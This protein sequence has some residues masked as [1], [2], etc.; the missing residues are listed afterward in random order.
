MI[1]ALPNHRTCSVIFFVVTS[2]KLV[3]SL[4]CI[5]YNKYL[6]KCL[7]YKVIKTFKSPKSAA[8]VAVGGA[9]VGGA[10]AAVGAVVGGGEER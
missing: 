5:L 10:A 2:L 4:T 6:Q 1:R 8:A 9:A 3:L 7:A